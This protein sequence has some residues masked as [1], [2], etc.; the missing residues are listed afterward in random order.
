MNEFRIKSVDTDLEL[1]LSDIK[2]EYFKVRLVSGHIN[3]VREVWAY[4]DAYGFADLMEHLAT[5]EKPWLEAQR[6]ESI[7]GEFKFSATCS[8]LGKVTFELEFCHY[9]C[10]EEWQVK[11]QLNSELGQLPKLAKSAKKFFGKSPS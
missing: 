3:V 4:T 7:E 6:W 1:I 11:T 10:S 2:G 9:G 5:Y 8:K